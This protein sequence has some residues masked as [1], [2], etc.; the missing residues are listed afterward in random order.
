MST[1]YASRHFEFGKARVHVM[2]GGEGEP[3]LFLH[4]AAGAGYWMPFHEMLAESFTVI[5][6]DHPGF[7]DSDALEWID[8][9]DDLV[10]FYLDLLERLDIERTHLLGASLGG[11]LA[12]ELAL[13]QPS[14]ARSLVLVDPIG[15]DIPEHPIEDI[16]AMNPDELRA[17]LFHDPDV[18]RRFIPE[19]PDFE[20]LMRAFKEKSAF[21][22]LA[23]NPFCCNPKLPLRTHR[24]AAPTLILWGRHDRLVPP[25]HG[26]RYRDLI[27]NSRL[28]FIEDSGHAPLLEQPRLTVDAIGKFVSETASGTP[29]TGG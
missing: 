28:E 10:Y 27:A 19:E 13:H 23:W 14:L 11:W 9:M 6:P 29:A 20:A 21:A 1:G 25:A 5:S 3:M 18:A 7:G 4:P 22:R 2:S 24:I 8:G 12:V 26:E 15:L 16:F 17:A